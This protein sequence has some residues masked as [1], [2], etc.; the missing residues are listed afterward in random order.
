MHDRWS[1]L[2]LAEGFQL[3]HAVATLYR[4]EVFE[5]LKRP[6]TVEALSRKHGLDAD[7]LRGT[8][9][10][11]LARTDLVRKIG[12]RYV[13]T[14]SYSAGSRFLLD[15]YLGA[16][17]NNARRL[18]DLL[19]DPSRAQNMIDRI[20]Y[21]RAFEAVNNSMLGI[22]PDLI[23]RLQFNHVLDV[24]C[25]SGELLLT[26]AKSDASFIGWG[27]DLNPS[28]CRVV[29]TRIRAA[30]AS[31][32]LRVLEGDCR[33]LSGLIPLN[34]R[35]RIQALVVSNVANEMFAN[36]SERIVVWLRELRDIFPDRPLLISDYYGRLGR[37][38]KFER[39]AIL[40][41]FVQL[42]SGQGIPPS[43][44]AEW[45]AIYKRAGC[46]LAHILEDK[47]TTRFIH[48]LRL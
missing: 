10:F 8:I 45:T 24:G 42:I 2:D 27:V 33:R 38:G 6:A 18:G 15:L 12:R 11:V 37:K 25:G 41:D 48:L 21:A 7:L 3:S 30:G 32:R 1:S 14:S 5:S 36:G 9:E 28:M 40:H 4:L 39:E 46:H 29:R 26:L 17:A 35:R 20:R 31:G 23:R 47:S 34:I 44:A 16:Y 13:T 22:V 43:D 19:C